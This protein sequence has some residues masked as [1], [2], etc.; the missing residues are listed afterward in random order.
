[1]Y[2][3]SLPAYRS[4]GFFK[5]ENGRIYL[6]SVCAGSHVVLQ[7]K[8]NG[9]SDGQTEIPIEM[10]DTILSFMVWKDAFYDKTNSL[11]YIQMCKE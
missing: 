5:I 3:L 6:N 10:E 1:M 2:T 11:S 9:V 7:Y 4:P 8:S